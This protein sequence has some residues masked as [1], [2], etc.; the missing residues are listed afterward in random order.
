MKHAFTLIELA[1][2]LIILGLLAGG[3]LYGQNLIRAAE[4][5]SVV[6][7]FEKYKTAAITFKGKYFYLPGDMPNATDFWGIAGGTTGSDAACFSSATGTDTDTCNGDGDGILDDVTAGQLYTE[8][9][10]FWQHLANAGLIN[11]QYTGQTATAGIRNCIS[12]E[13]TPSARISNMSW[14]VA[15]AGNYGGDSE[16]YALDYGNLI[17]PALCTTTATLYA[18]FFSPEEAWNIDTKIDDGKPGYGQVIARFWGTTTADNACT[19]NAADETDLES[20][21]N[22]T[23]S[24]LRCGL[25]FIKVF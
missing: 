4:L 22:L 12:S 7:E 11:G 13:N 6:S 15:N 25:H 17:S 14:F 20:D 8:L 24:S 2:V 5:R 19:I 3:V 16:A 21:Y 18:P 10:M 9:F 23:D 1:I